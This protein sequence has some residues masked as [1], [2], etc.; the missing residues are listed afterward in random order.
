MKSFIKLYL[1]GFILTQVVFAEL[2]VGK[3]FY[4]WGEKWVIENLE[5]LGCSP[6]GI[7]CSFEGGGSYGP[8]YCGMAGYACID[9]E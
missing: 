5:H 7:M 8:R 2:H 9:E 4:M 6:Y 1:A 3:E